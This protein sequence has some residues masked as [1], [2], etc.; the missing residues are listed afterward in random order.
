MAQ[1]PVICPGQVIGPRQP[2]EKF[3]NKS[4]KFFPME[5]F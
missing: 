4:A 3:E 2:S 1:D 5:K